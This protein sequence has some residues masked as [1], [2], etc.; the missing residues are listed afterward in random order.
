MRTGRLV[1]VRSIFTFFF[2]LGFLRVFFFFY[3]G[4]RGIFD[5]CPAMKYRLKRNNIPGTE[6]KVIIIIF[7]LYAFM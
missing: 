2:S 7:I 5:F 3:E 4:E 1:C 6:I